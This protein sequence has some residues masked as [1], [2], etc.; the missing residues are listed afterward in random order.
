MCGIFAY[1]GNLSNTNKEDLKPHIEK[2][3][4]RGPDNSKIMK[5]N[6]SL[7][8]GFHRL[9]I[10]GTNESGDQPL[11]HPNDEN[12][13]LI[14]NG[15]IYNYKHLAEK[16]D[17]SL[18]TGSDCE[19]ILH[20]YKEF[21]IQQT[22]K[23]LDGVFMFLLYDKKEKELYAGRDP[24][25][26]RPGFIGYEKDN[27]LFSS[28]AKAISDICKRIIPFPP[29]HWWKD[30]KPLSFNK[31]YKNKIEYHI[32]VNKNDIL[33]GIR[34]RLIESVKK[35]MMSDREIGSLLSGGLDSSLISAL[36]NKFNTGEKLK[37]FSIGMPG[38][39][40]LKY[41][42]EVATFIDSDHHQIEISESTF[43]QSIETVIYNIE[44]YDTTTVRAS[45]GNYLVSKYI[46]E[47][48]DCKVIFNG[49]G[50]DE[51]CG[52]YLYMKNAPSP[53]D[54]QKECE[55]L[56]SEI[57][58]FDVLRSD[59][60][61][62]CNG[63]EA[64]TPFLDKEFV[65][66]Y[67]SINPKEKT[68][69]DSNRI[70]KHLLRMAFSKMDILP[71]SIL[72]RRKCAFSDGV[73]SQ[74][75]SWHLVLKKFI[76]EQIS[77]LEFESESL[78]ISHCRPLFKESYYYRKIFESFF[79]KHEKLIPYYWMPKW[80]NTVDPSAREISGYIE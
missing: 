34:K 42:K 12:L 13:V 29:G 28:E 62:S 35:R 40:D 39:V 4:Y 26:V 2:I 69:N 38:S 48:S 9:A 67:L 27:I 17:F 25:G 1:R 30:D 31:Y 47:N 61:I 11:F 23:S 74:Q 76:D 65:S 37:T 14:C 50:S 54:F 43:L 19:I 68:F 45:I 63:L 60:S 41:A 57:Y 58:R 8:F 71:K 18:K 3:S 51:V 21:G 80:V 10:V 64:R 66:Y 33:E 59:R 55:R 73:S 36:V 56:V 15:E 16:H 75:K 79:P 5:F 7:F 72:W 77:D 20:M 53:L 22:I 46:R 32:D 52:G 70:E 78:K 49:D 6:D 24:F 44:S